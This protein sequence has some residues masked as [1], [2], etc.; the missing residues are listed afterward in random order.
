VKAEIDPD[1]ARFI[2]HA[3]KDA[4][5]QNFNGGQADMESAILVLAYFGLARLDR[6]PTPIWRFTGEIR[7]RGIREICKAAYRSRKRNRSKII[8][9]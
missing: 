1:L 2:R 4:G 3:A 6:N 8:Q 7:R 5:S 9:I